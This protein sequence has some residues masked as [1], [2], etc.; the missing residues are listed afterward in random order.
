MSTVVAVDAMGGDFAPREVVQ[1]ALQAAAALDLQVLLVGLPEAIEKALDG[2]ALPRNVSVV[3]ASDV[4]SM[5]DEPAWAVRAKKDSS[6]VVAARM[7]KEGRAGAF[8]SAG[9]TGATM[10]AAL[11]VIGRIPGVQRP[12]IATPIPTPS[13]PVVLVDAGANSECRPEHLLQFAKMAHVYAASVLHVD[14]PKVGL[15]SIGEEPSKGD[16]VVQQTFPLLKES[17]LD[18]VGNVQGQDIPLGGVD[19][20]VTD[21]FTGNVVLKVMEGMVEA[22]FSQLSASIVGSLK[23]EAGSVLKPLLIGLKKKLDREEYGGAPLLGVDGVC[24][25][26]HGSSSAKSIANAIAR[27]REACDNDVV[28]K[29]RAEI[30]RQ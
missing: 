3:A 9:N 18:F 11:L 12:A 8:V 29:L 19:I 13:G 1:G 30:A 14:G 7:V 27:A 16:E 10:A 26:C 24:I 17:G 22:M 4:I 20:V 2:K 6:M 21:G 28:G 23:P 15:L 25:I 5:Q